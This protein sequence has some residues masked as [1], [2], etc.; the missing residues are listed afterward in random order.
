M[1]YERIFIAQAGLGIV[2]RSTTERKKMSTKTLRKRIALVAVASLGFGV[3]TSISANAATVGTT[4]MT[5]PTA[6]VAVGSVASSTFSVTTAGAT[7][8][9][10]ITYSYAITGKP[11]D[12]ALAKTGAT[13]T[14]SATPASGIAKL[15]AGTETTDAK[16]ART[17][18]TDTLIDTIQ[19]TPTELNSVRGTIA[20]T[21]DKAGIYV[22][23]VTSTVSVG[24][25]STSTATFTVYAGYSVN[26]TYANTAFPTQ[27]TNTSTGWA[28]TNPGQATVRFT[29][30]STSTTKKYYVTASG[31]SISSYTEREDAGAGNSDTLSAFTNTNNTNLADGFYFTSASSQV[32]DAVDVTITPNAGVSSATVTV[33]YFDATTGAETI[34]SVATVTFGAASSITGGQSTSVLGSGTGNSAVSGV[35][36]VVTADATAGTQRANVTI[37]L[38]DQYGNA[39]Y[40]QTL[41]ATISGPGLIRFSQG[42]QATQGT[43]RA[44]SLVLTSSQNTAF[45]GVNGDGS[46]GVATIT[47]SA[48]TTVIGTETVTFYGSAKTLTAKAYK[49][50]L[51]VGSNTDALEVLAVD[52]NGNAATYTPT[53]VSDAIGYVSGSVSN[54]ARATDA[55]V[56]AGYTKNAYYCDITG[57]AK[58]SANLTVAKDSTTT[59]SPVVKFQVTG[60]VAY[61]VS[62]STDKKT[63]A[64]GEKVT[65]KISATDID[66][67]AIGAGT[68]DFLNGASTA[69]QALT[70]TAFTDAA[71]AFNNGF[72]TTTYYAPLVGGPFTFT[73]SLNNSAAVASAIASTDVTT[74]AS[75]SADSAVTALINSL[76]TK[77]N[78]LAA[79]VAKIQKKLGVK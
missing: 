79:L 55:E 57:V 65:L 18:G 48:G 51:S 53:A 26:S 15:V 47:I 58:G 23:T 52:A 35:D 74:S 31:A 2:S 64:P 42:T 69:S 10:V 75:V 36:D 34:F 56:L 24:S 6:S 66:G 70:G 45:L 60:S 50:F 72:A 63:Y 27:G 12:S 73:A 33:K 62:L 61:K 30:F 41:S 59:N 11:S 77:I 39:A 3:L 37:T 5:T 76:M 9:D 7:A 43:V 13:T 78:A 1:T 38:K 29:N 44:D 46:G 21:P 14:T 25:S 17:L 28:A 67:N 16:Y 19:A 49:P 8:S 22:I 54:C 20:L 4:T 40:G 32:A 68:Y 71:F